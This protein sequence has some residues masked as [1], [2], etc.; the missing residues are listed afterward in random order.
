[1]GV[2]FGCFD[3]GVTHHLL[4]DSDVNT[5][6]EQMRSKTVPKSMAAYPFGDPCFIDSSLH[7]LL[8][9]RLKHMVST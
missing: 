5:I 2:N 7:G 9:A 6:F 4:N 3:I 8:Q 1:M